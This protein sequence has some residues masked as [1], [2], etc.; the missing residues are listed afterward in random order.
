MT[1]DTTLP[2]LYTVCFGNPFDSMTFFGVFLTEEEANEWCKTQDEGDLTI[3]TIFDANVDAVVDA[4][5][6]D[7]GN[8]SAASDEVSEAATEP[9]PPALVMPPQPEAAPVESKSDKLDVL[10]E[11]ISSMSTTLGSLDERLSRVE[12]PVVKR[13]A[14]ETPA[15]QQATLPLKSTY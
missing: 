13:K 12:N 15:P 11:A 4:V 14:K 8:E 10:L 9:T 1:T 6:L 3:V 2:V 7:R 5:N